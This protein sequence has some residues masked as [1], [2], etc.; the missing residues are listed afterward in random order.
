MKKITLFLLFLN[1]V[2]GQDK[3]LNNWFKE[4]NTSGTF[5]FYD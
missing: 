2:F 4:Y 3:I 5:V 1:L